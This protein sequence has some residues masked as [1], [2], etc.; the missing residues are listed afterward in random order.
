MSKFNILAKQYLKEKVLPVMPGTIEEL[1]DGYYKILTALRNFVKQN[2][3]YVNNEDALKGT[4]I[5]QELV[6]LTQDELFQKLI[7]CGVDTYMYGDADSALQDVL[8][9]N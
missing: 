5:Y 6:E 7:S 2:P 4:D 1:V 8:E 9:G 3:D